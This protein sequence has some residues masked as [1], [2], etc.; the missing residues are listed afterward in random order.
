MV[1]DWFNSNEGCVCVHVKKHGDRPPCRSSAAT[2][3]AHTP[4]STTTTTTSV[5]LESVVVRGGKW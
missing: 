3:S 5:S 4:S 2:Y 1:Y